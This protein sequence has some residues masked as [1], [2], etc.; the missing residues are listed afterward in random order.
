MLFKINIECHGPRLKYIL[1]SNRICAVIKQ[2]SMVNAVYL[3]LS[4]LNTKMWSTLDWQG[5]FSQDVYD[6]V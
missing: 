3:V 1:F 6:T 5:P 4:S 2:H